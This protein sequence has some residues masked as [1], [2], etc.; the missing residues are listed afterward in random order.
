MYSY[1]I[2]GTGKADMG[3]WEQNRRVKTRGQVQKR[4]KTKMVERGQKK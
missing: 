4:W 1:C 2:K 3:E